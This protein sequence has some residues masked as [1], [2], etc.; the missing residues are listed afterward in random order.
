MSHIHFGKGL[1]FW[2]DR[3]RL[4]ATK[5]RINT[6]VFVLIRAF[7]AFKLSFDLSQVQYKSRK[8]RLS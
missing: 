1:R 3:F 2:L 4:K 6:N 7:V 8:N 5:A